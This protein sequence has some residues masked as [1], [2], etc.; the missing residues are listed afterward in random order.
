MLANLVLG[1]NVYP[2]FLQEDCT[3]EKLAAALLPLLADTEARKAQLNEL[4]RTPEKLRLTLVKSERGG[5]RNRAF[6]YRSSRRREVA[7]LR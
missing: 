2:E 3:A 6:R 5:C 1:R 7:A 4:A